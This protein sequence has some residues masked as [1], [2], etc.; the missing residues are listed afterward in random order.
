MGWPANPRTYP[1]ARQ[2]SKI[3]LHILYRM[4][5]LD[6]YFTKQMQDRPI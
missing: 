4:G 2:A 5:Q 3:N 1:Y 6:S